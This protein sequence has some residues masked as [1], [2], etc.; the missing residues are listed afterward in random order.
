MLESC[1]VDLFFLNSYFLCFSAHLPN[2]APL[3]RQF[4]LKQSN[5]RHKQLQCALPLSAWGVALVSKVE[6]K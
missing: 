1:K 3:G 5:L 2:E 6:V 4:R